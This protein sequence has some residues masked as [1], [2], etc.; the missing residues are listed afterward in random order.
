MVKK[1]IKH[2]KNKKKTGK[3]KAKNN[4]IKLRQV[5]QPTYKT[6]NRLFKEY[7]QKNMDQN[8]S[9][10]FL[11]KKKEEGKPT[12]YTCSKH[13]LSTIKQ[14]YKPNDPTRQEYKKNLFI[15]YL[16]NVFCVNLD[17]TVKRHKPTPDKKRK[18]CKYNIVFR[19]GHTNESIYVYRLTAIFFNGKMSTWF[20]QTLESLEDDKKTDFL[21]HGGNAHHIKG[22]GNNAKDIILLS[23]DI[24]ELQHHKNKQIKPFKRGK[25]YINE[26]AEIGKCLDRESDG[27]G[28]MIIEGKGKDQP[29]YTE[30]VTVEDQK[31][32]YNAFINMCTESVECDTNTLIDELIKNGQCKNHNDFYQKVATNQNMTVDQAKKSIRSI[33]GTFWIKEVFKQ[34]VI[35]FN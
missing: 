21:L 7:V 3:A 15:S 16:G 18:Y 30:N 12:T 6:Y 9:V 32:L 22:V 24:H 26:L 10:T 4:K 31:A 19:E 5:K 33:V 2:L 35:Q 8:G 27:N 1:K 29:I 28:A 25:I 17:G 20:K 23:K 13:E 34:E 11:L 14:M